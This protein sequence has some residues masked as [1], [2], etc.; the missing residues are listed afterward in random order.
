MKPLIIVVKNGVVDEVIVTTKETCE[1]DFLN[2]V[3]SRISNYD[4]YTSD[5]K[6]VIIEN[7]YETYGTGNS[8]CLTWVE[9]N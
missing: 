9:L 4:S 6:D 8:V 3:A 1:Q 7:G 5:D 2:A